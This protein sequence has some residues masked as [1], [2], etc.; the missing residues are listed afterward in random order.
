[1]CHE[2]MSFASP[3]CNG[4]DKLDVAQVQYLPSEKVRFLSRASSVACGPIFCKGDQ[5][6]SLSLFAVVYESRRY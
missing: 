4:V 1:M 3:I 5:R 2:H 6:I